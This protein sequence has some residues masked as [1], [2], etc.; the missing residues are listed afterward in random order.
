MAHQHTRRPLTSV[1]YGLAAMCWGVMPVW[2]Y[3]SGRLPAYLK[4]QFQTYALIGGLGL[5]ILG[6]F[7]LLTARDSSASCGHDHHHDHHHDHDH[8]HGHGDHEHSH[9]DQ[10][11][12]VTVLLMIVPMVLAVLVTE[13]EY[14]EAFLRRKGVFNDN[15][16]AFSSY[17]SNLPPYTRETLEKNTPKNA[18][19]EYLMEIPQ[20]YWSAGDEEVMEVLKGIPVE[21]QGKVIA[22]EEGGNPGHNRLRL[23]QLL[24]TCC[25][26]DAA[27][28]GM[29]IEFEGPPPDLPPRTWVRVTGTVAYE[30]REDYPVVYLKVNTIEEAPEPRS[31][32]PFF[33]W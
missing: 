15:R 25:A 21:V 10:N 14:S 26:A 24:M 32:N 13:D 2:F 3:A 11:P 31:R 23:Y 20:L 8:D 6:L 5:I 12:L 29:S 9:E 16:E 33:P 22:E 4:D 30:T 28:L 19:G 17:L 27:V 7:N 18:E 1:V